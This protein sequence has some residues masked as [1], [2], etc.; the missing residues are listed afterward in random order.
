MNTQ[1]ELDLPPP[2]FEYKNGV[3]DPAKFFK[4]LLS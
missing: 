4:P 3:K 2:A 1:E